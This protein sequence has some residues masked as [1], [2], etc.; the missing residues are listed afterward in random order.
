MSSHAKNKWKRNYFSAVPSLKL[1]FNFCTPLIPVEVKLLPDS[2]YQ[3]THTHTHRRFVFVETLRFALLIMTQLVS[4]DSFPAA[5]P[6]L[7][8][9]SLF[10]LLWY[11]LRLNDTADL[12]LHRLWAH[13][14]RLFHLGL[15]RSTPSHSITVQLVLPCHAVYRRVMAYEIWLH[16]TQYQFYSQ[17]IHGKLLSFH[18]EAHTLTHTHTHTTKKAAFHSKV[19]LQTYSVNPNPWARHWTCKSLSR[20]CIKHQHF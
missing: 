4:V 7:C 15:P 6:C 17:T 9:F 1:K 12:C 18:F 5:S 14:I 3:L 11:V 16:F 10:L 19:S 20:F 13:F 8:W 2:W